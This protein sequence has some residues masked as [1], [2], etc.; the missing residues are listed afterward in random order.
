MASLVGR[1]LHLE[2]HEA[3]SGAPFYVSVLLSGR[4][5]SVLSGVASGATLAGPD[6][7]PS[8][9][10][11]VL[12]RVPDGDGGDLAA[13]TAIWPTI[14]SRSAPISTRRDPAAAPAA[15]AAELSASS[16]GGEASGLSQVS[17]AAHARLAGCPSGRGQRPRP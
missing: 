17:Q 7:L 13:P 2:L 6:P 5:A 12:L 16:R 14:R 1:I 10:R 9:T 8:T 4:P 3:G 15:A 11:I